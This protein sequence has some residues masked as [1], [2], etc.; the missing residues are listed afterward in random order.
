MSYQHQPTAAR[1]KMGTAV[2]RLANLARLFI[3]LSWYDKH[4]KYLPCQPSE[5]PFRSRF[6]VVVKRADVARYASEQQNYLL[7]YHLE[8]QRVQDGI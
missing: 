7:P 5:A 2:I 1:L 6:R 4:I 8:P 3:N